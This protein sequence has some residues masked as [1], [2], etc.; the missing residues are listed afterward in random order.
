MAQSAVEGLDVGILGRRP[1]LRSPGPPTLWRCI[2]GE[3][4]DAAG[5][6]YELFAAGDF[7]GATDCF[8]PDCITVTPAGAMGTT[9]HEQ[10]G[11]AFKAALPDAHMVVDRA[12]ELDDSVAIEG[13][14]EGRHT[15]DLV[16]PQGTIPASG[17]N[18]DMPF[19]DFFRVR[20]GRIVEHRVYWDQMTMTTQLGALPPQ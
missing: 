5:Q 11:R 10:F 8:D 19:A 18:L 4:L 17:A 9:D 1:G 16:T 14:F 20:G 6:Y 2:I 15:A 3:A 7:E 12:I 13:R